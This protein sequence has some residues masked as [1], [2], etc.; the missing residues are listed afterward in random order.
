MAEYYLNE[1][2]RRAKKVLKERGVN[3]S[4]VIQKAFI[5]E[6]GLTELENPY[7]ESIKALQKKSKAWDE[8]INKVVNTQK[9]KERKEYAIEFRRLCSVKYH[10]NKYEDMKPL[11]KLINKRVTKNLMIDIEH[12]PE[13]DP[14]KWWLDNYDKI[15]ND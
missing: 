8:E 9:S 14:F 4:Q 5:A 2:A 7:V 11:L 6:A 13:F 1:D 15:Q 3:L 12:N 10:D